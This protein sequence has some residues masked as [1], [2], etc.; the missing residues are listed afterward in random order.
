MTSLTFKEKKKTYLKLVKRKRNNSELKLLVFPQL[1]RNLLLYYFKN[2][3]EMKV[4][5]EK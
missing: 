1:L 2:S 3:I 4:D 5:T